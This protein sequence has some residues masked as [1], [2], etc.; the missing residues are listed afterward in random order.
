MFMTGAILHFAMVRHVFHQRKP[1]ISEE[2]AV[3]EMVDMALA[4][5]ARRADPGG[6][7]ANKTQKALKKAGHA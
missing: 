2:V 6:R 7:V 5:L 4:G 1:N 3:R